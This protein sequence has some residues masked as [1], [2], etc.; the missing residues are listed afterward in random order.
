M[1]SESDIDIGVGVVSLKKWSWVMHG[2]WGKRR[3][4]KE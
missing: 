4:R 2:L 3:R 1:T